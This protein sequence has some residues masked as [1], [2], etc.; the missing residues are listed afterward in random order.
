MTLQQLR[1]RIDRI[2]RKLLRLLNERAALAMRIGGL[3]KKKGLPVFDGK[4][5]QAVLRRLERASR[6]PLPGVSIKKIF[7]DILFQS[8]KLQS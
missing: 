6:G 8:R 3:K 4:R 1:N 2:D 5:E 7:R